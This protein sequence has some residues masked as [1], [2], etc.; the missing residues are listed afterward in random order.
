VNVTQLDIRFENGHEV[1]AAYWG[2]LCDGGLVIPNRGELNEG[3]PVRLRVRIASSATRVELGGTV[4]RLRPGEHRAVV[5]FDRGAPHDV[6]LSTALAEADD[7]PPRRY[8]RHR[9]TLPAAVA[10]GAAPVCGQLIDVSCAGCCLQL[11]DAVP[12]AVGDEVE[13]TTEAFAAAGTVVWGHGRER[14]V[15]FDHVGVPGVEQ[16][17]DSL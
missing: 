7:V 1:L 5:A 15:C 4:V 11:D 14:G 2:F 3:Q 16:L 12:L 6:L 13:V 17:I 10:G 8:R 9:V